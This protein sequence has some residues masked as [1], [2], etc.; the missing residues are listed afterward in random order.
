MTKILIS[1]LKIA[2]HK[3]FRLVV[4]LFVRKRSFVFE[5]ILAFNSSLGC[6][7]SLYQ[8]HIESPRLLAGAD[9]QLVCAVLGNCDTC[10]CRL[11]AFAVLRGTLICCKFVFK[12][13]NS[14]PK[15]TASR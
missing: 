6:L 4:C 3:I 7:L 12:L 10:S 5:C 13:P 9:L 8:R 11:N 1:A 15:T 2:L 14:L